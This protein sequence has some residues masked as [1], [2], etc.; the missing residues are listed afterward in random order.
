[1]ILIKYLFDYEKKKI[2]NLYLEF[3]EIKYIVIFVGVLIIV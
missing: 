1:M 3:I 2:V